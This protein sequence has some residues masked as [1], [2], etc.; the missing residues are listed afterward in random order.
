MANFF[1]RQERIE[2]YYRARY[3]EDIQ[4]HPAEVFVDAVDTSLV[5]VIFQ[6]RTKTGVAVIPA[7][8]S[9]IAANYVYIGPAYGDH[10]YIRRDLAAGAGIVDDARPCDQ[11]ALRCFV[12]APGVLQPVE[13][14]P[15]PI[16]AS[17]A[18]EATFTPETGL[19][20]QAVVFAAGHSGSG[21]PNGFRLQSV[22]GDLY[23]FAIAA[24]GGWRYS[25]L[26]TLPTRRSTTFRA[27]FASG[28][29]T[30]FVNGVVADKLP[31]PL[32]I[33]PSSITVGSDTGGR[34][35][36]IGKIQHF[37]IR[38]SRDGR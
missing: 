16:P 10:L 19:Q 24:E 28:L 12:A 2:N 35:V 31:A 20:G 18:V 27:E 25:R 9:Y 37:E 14:P 34:H 23:R 5:S 22:D 7:I 30:I 1:R 4:R 26:L 13:L 8:A 32:R 21:A 36:F 17:A 29:V 3:L 11:D 6:D 15:V 33:S 38:G